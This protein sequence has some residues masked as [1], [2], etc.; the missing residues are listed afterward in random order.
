MRVLKV[1]T[2]LMLALILMSASILVAQNTSVVAPAGT[3]KVKGQVKDSSGL[4]MSAVDVRILQGTGKNPKVIKQGVTNSTGEFDLDVP[5]GDYRVEITAPDF[6]PFDKAV[7]ASATMDPL[8]VTL[9]LA[10]IS[11]VV[12]VNGD[13]TSGGVGLDPSSSLTGTTLTGDDLLELPDDPDDLLAYLLQLAQIDELEPDGSNLIVD[14]IAGAPLPPKDTIAEIRIINNP[15]SAEY[16]GRPTIQIVTKS[17]T[18]VWRGSAST[19]FNNQSLNA[20]PP[21][22]KDGAVKPH[23]MVRNFSSNV[24]GPLIKNKMSAN[25]AVQNQDREAESSPLRA[26]VPLPDG[27]LSSLTNTVISPNLNRTFNLQNASLSVIPN[28][29]ITFNTSYG[30]RHASNTGVGGFNLPE[31]ASSTKSTN[32]SF[33]ISDQITVNSKIV[34]TAT[35]STN[36]S[37]SQTLPGT[38]ASQYCVGGFACNVQ[39]AFNGGTP[40]N[41]SDSHNKTYQ[42]SNQLR[43][44]L[45][46]R[47]QLTASI[48]ANYS[49]N[50]SNAQNNAVGTFTFRNI[51]DYLAGNPLQFTQTIYKDPISD[52]KSLGVTTYA[53]GEFRINNKNQLSM[54]ARYAV[55]LHDSDYNNMAPTLGWSH[56]INRTTVIRMGGQM[57]YSNSVAG[58]Y[59][60][61]FRNDGS[62]RQLNVVISN[63]AY[64]DPFAAGT[65]SQSA[66]ANSFAVRSDKSV[67]PYTITQTY[68]I[69]KS[70][71]PRGLRVSVQ[72][73]VAR[74]VHLLRTRNINAPYPGLP[75]PTDLYAR[76]SESCSPF[77]QACVAD[78]AAAQTEVDSMRP[79]Y[80]N[81]ATRINETD[82]T[83][84]S[85][86]KTLNIQW[87]GLNNQRFL[88][89]KVSLNFSGSDRITWAY[90]SGNQPVNSYD[91]SGE[92]ARTNTPRNQFSARFQLT[93]PKAFS[94]NST[95]TSNT[96]R[97]YNITTGI[98]NNGD[99]NTNDR[100]LGMPRNAGMG[101]GTTQLGTL[102]VTKR[103][104]L[105]GGTAPKP[106][107]TNAAAFGEPQRGG[108]GGG[109][110]GGF[111]G[112]GGGG[113]GG[114]AGG[115]TNPQNQRTLTLTAQISNP[116][117]S[118]TKS[119]VVGNMSSPLFGQ[120]TGGGS[121]RR[122]QLTLAMNFPR[123]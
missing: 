83:G 24:G 76:W 50:V 35:F 60:N 10:A 64:P 123:L 16:N 27:T 86:G 108:G 91:I 49:R 11:T 80:P 113:N 61:L 69:E 14:G 55:Y 30:D 17:G 115:L 56:Q 111:G 6:E 12:N 31:R 70:G 28:H 67:D 68:Q 96:G 36:G 94:L 20:L 85:A 102:S 95:L 22:S 81:F 112:G 79:L 41:R 98:D 46:P 63:P 13:D 57:S 5:P 93:F 15:F 71:L 39:E 77:N 4:V 75:L 51:N 58:Q 54:G 82:W 45:S 101:P 18:G 52:I 62:S 43:M 90:D 25:F 32:S 9:S 19:T 8:A 97:P 122:I 106:I 99:S 120:T 114:N 73:Q 116:L 40:Q 59:Q 2:R 104:F 84:T 38:G 87:S 89:K 26:I 7:R 47:W 48:T 42:T 121:G 119:N 3:V 53:Q 1:S 21:L 29:R 88:W 110:G 118:T 78:K 34:D 72:L 107:T 65:L 100:P 103:F 74:G 105:G 109:G 33:S 37:H 44:T 23:S 66:Q 117:N 92:W